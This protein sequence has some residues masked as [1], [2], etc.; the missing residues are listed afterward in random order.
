[1][2]TTR[3]VTTT[4]LLIALQI[5]LTRFFSFETATLRVG[6]GFLP[7]ALS[8]ILFGP[9]T[10]GVTAALSDIIGMLLFPKSMYFPGF[11][12]SAFI[13]GVI[14]GLLL[15][16]DKYSLK[17]VFFAVLLVTL[18]CDLGLNTLWLLIITG[19]AIGVI[20]MSRL[21]KSA[22]MF[23]IQVIMIH[24]VWKHLNLIEKN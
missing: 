22:A 15:Y 3:K 11:T 6:F 12:L 10:A 19:K 1:M 7:I 2:K 16:K 8:A 24:L 14:Y 9:L 21:I 20:F 13:S 4:G 18:I 5:I 23:P 17:N